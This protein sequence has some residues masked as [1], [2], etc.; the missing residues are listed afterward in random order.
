MH[1]Q[2]ISIHKY[3]DVNLIKS[4]VLYSRRFIHRLTLY[5]VSTSISVHKINI[6]QS[7]GK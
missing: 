4:N 3:Y 2:I 5:T 1:A 7:T 6:T